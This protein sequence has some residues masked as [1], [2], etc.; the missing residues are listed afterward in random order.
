MTSAA[1]E[2]HGY[3]D[4]M[5]SCPACGR[6]GLR[7]G[8]GLED[9]A[10]EGDVEFAAL[11]AAQF[12]AMTANGHFENMTHCD[13]CFAYLVVDLAARVVRIAAPET[14]LGWIHDG[15]PLAATLRSPW[16]DHWGIVDHIGADVS[17]VLEALWLTRDPRLEALLERCRSHGRIAWNRLGNETWEPTPRP[18]RGHGG[19]LRETDHE[20]IEASLA[21]VC[22]TPPPLALVTA[23]HERRRST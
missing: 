2:D 18:L 13:G 17:L 21:A 6:D 11:S 20:C 5:T 12:D 1:D 9:G 10:S 7:V 19:A 4:V 23:A 22:P 8:E 14:I 3:Y 15:V 16:L